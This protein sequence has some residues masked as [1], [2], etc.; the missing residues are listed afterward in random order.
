MV[1]SRCQQGINSR[2]SSVKNKPFFKKCL[3]V[4]NCDKREIYKPDFAIV[5]KTNRSY[6]DQF[7]VN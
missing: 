1:L 7:E 2:I 5:P 4:G 3:T 6:F